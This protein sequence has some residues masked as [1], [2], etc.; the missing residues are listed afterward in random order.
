MFG[1]N[2]RQSNTFSVLIKLTLFQSLQP[3]LVF[4]KHFF[5]CKRR[6]IFQWACLFPSFFSLSEVLSNLLSPLLIRPASA[7]TYPFL[8]LACKGGGLQYGDV[9]CLSLTLSLSACL[10]LSLSVWFL[11]P[12]GMKL[13]MLRY[14]EYVCHYFSHVFF[15]L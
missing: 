12:T 5:L 14:G 4:L 15:I 1:E 13:N 11:T 10:F 2:L 7:Q 3:T 8:S 6:D 9:Y